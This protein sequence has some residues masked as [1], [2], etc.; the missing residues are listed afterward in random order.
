MAGGG[1]KGG[2]AYGSTDEFGHRA[3]ENVV[4]PN[5]FQA[6]LLHLMGMDHT[7]L[8]YQHNGREE[9]LTSAAPTARIV[10]ELLA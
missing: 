1:I 4:T 8:I 9:R 10:K 2:M 5:D 6:T 3:V 7:K